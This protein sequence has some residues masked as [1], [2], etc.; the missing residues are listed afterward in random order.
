MISRACG[1][2]VLTDH[3]RTDPHSD[4]SALLQAEQFDIVNAYMDFLQFWEGPPGPFRFGKLAQQPINWE[5]CY[6]A[7]FCHFCRLLCALQLKSREK[8]GIKI[9]KKYTIYHND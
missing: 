2:P 3:G 4:Y 9:W 8:V 6:S 1:N 7:Q 5:I